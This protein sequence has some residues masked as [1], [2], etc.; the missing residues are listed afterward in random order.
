MK[1]IYYS[2]RLIVTLALLSFVNNSNAQCPYSA[3]PY[4]SYTPA[5]SGAQETAVF[6]AWGGDYITIDVVAG[7]TYTFSTCGGVTYDTQLTLFTA[8]GGSVLGFNDDGCGLQSTITWVATFTGVVEVQLNQFPCTTNTTCTPIYVTCS[9][10]APPPTPCTSITPLIGCGTSTGATLT[11]T[12][13]G[14]D[15]TSCG[16]STP[17]TEIIF[18]FTATS[19]G[20]HSIDVTGITGGFVDFFWM[21]S[22]TGCSS[23]P[24]DWNCIADVGF[25]GN[26]G[27]MNWTA[28]ETYYILLDPEGTGTYDVVFDVDCPNPTGPVT[29][30]DCSSAI[31][32]CTDLGFQ[33]DPSGFGLVDELCTNCTSNPSINPSSANDGC[34][35][36]GELHS[37]WFTVNVAAGGMLEFSFG[38]PGAGFICYD[39]IMWDYDPATTCSNIV[40]DVQA[41]VSCNWNGNCDGFTGVSNTLPAGAFADNFEPGMAVNAGDQFVICFSNFNSNVTTVPLNF[42][43]SADISCTPLPVGLIDFDG[44]NDGNYNTLFWTTGAEIHSSHFDVE[45]SIDGETFE[46]IATVEASGMS[47]S[48]QDYTIIDPN[49][50]ERINYYRLRCVDNDN[51]FEYSE[52]IAISGEKGDD[53]ALVSAYPNPASNVFNIQLV[54][55]RD[56]VLTTTVREMNGK[57]VYTSQHTAVKGGN[58]FTIPVGSFSKGFY[59]VSIYNERTQKT[60]TLK[61]TLQ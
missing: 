41:P 25:T 58:L 55:S 46:T 60:E 35:L 30:G 14:W 40:N 47:F 7:N 36:N 56:E 22:T 29:A 49:P 10:G 26:Y 31:P 28:G 27:S 42:F 52:V 15:I 3:N 57:E 5:C 48:A 32:V 21:N 24:A 37:T 20:V 34:L 19:T 4:L 16:F 6:C 54:S 38:A 51:S 13:A 50:N 2:L 33:I 53:F 18:S 1:P 39:W 8:G 9:G 23:N 17:G 61:L 12:G 45:R 44:K 43:G 59:F 11:G